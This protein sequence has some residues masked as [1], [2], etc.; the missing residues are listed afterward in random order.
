MISMGSLKCDFKN[1]KA[2]R[3]LYHQKFGIL[4]YND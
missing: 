4:I 2:L 3:A 1:D